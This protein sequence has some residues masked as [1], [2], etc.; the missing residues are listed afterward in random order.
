[1]KLKV[2]DIRVLNLEITSYCNIQCP[3]CSRTNEDGKLASYVDLEHWDSK[4]ILSNLEI[5]QMT[6]LNFVNIEGDTG[7]ALMHPD[8]E[9][10][11]DKLYNSPNKP[12]IIILTHGAIRST[13]W[14]ESFGSKF[15]DRLSVQFSID[16]LEDTHKL[17]RV[18]AD[19]NKVIANVK[20]FIKGGGYATSRCLV[21]KHNQHQLDQI[22][23]VGRN[24]GFQYF[25]FVPGDPLRY[26]G[27]E[28]W[29]V[30]ENGKFTHII[31]PTSIDNFDKWNWEPHELRN[32]YSQP[33]IYNDIICSNLKKGEIQITYKG[34][35]IP[36]C[37][38][39]ADLYFDHPL[40]EPF[41]K[42]VGNI[43]QFNVNKQKLSEILSHSYFDR[44]EETLAKGRDPGRC[45]DMCSHLNLKREKI[46]F[47]SAQQ[48]PIKC[49]N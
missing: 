5:D 24:L 15:K 25:K 1:M 38:Y 29:K 8:I 47:I 17:Y 43:D 23:E 41:Q 30:Y 35:V 4:L 45:S 11:V 36:C 9:N 44:L 42:L 33:I 19:Y 3:Q 46:Y 39:N 7:D 16:G 28:Y 10:I 21:F 49:Q 48:I 12:K 31:E 37:M 27:Q 14:W 18:G 2:S 22:A 40:N 26:R 6:N 13:A 32:V 20:S 34:H